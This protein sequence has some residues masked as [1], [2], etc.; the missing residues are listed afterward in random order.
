MTNRI[1]LIAQQQLSSLNALEFSDKMQPVAC[2]AL[3]VAAAA[4]QAAHNATEVA[5]AARAFG[6]W[7]A[8]AAAD[9]GFVRTEAPSGASLTSEPLPVSGLLAFR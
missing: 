8:T 3:E 9:I 4:A 1:E 7:I 6:R 5:L 2:A